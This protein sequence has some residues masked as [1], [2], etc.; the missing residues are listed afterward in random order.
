MVMDTVDFDGIINDVNDL[1]SNIAAEKEIE[2]KINKDGAV[3]TLL[4][5]DKFRLEQ[6]VKNLLSNA[7]KF[8]AR[9]GQVTFDI[10]L[11]P[12]NAKYQNELLTRDDIEV[13][14]FTVKDTGIGIP[15][16]KQSSI[17][18]A[19]K[20]ADGG[21]SRRYG[22]S[23]L[24]LSI[25]RQLASLLGGEIQLE[26]EV[27]KGS[28]FHLFLP[29]VYTAPGEA[30]IRIEEAEANASAAHVTLKYNT[31]PVV[32]LQDIRDVLREKTILIV[33]DDTRNIKSLIAV[34]QP[35]GPN[36]LTAET[37]IDALKVI[38]RRPAIDMALMDVMMPGLDGYDTIKRIRRKEKYK[39][40][41]I[42]VITARTMKEDREKSFEAGAS[43]YLSKPIDVQHLLAMM[44]IWLSGKNRM[45]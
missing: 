40:L 43:D 28:S 7:F 5:T 31:I 11:A 29:V 16:E 3:P 9:G 21:T 2:F 17:F 15:P 32:P 26:S 20:Q 6:I 24:G 19:F 27:G 45:Q 44:A 25:S 23:G 13:L 41:P 36:I 38:E 10:E 12:A 18:E 1:F 8:T 37:G 39:K 14:R 22:G 30:V 35:Y 33:D 4:R 42:I 34:L